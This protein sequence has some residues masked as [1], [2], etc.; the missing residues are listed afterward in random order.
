MVLESYGARVCL[1]S[2]PQEG[3]PWGEGD[4]PWL[5]VSESLRVI[6]PPR[7]FHLG[8]AA[9]SVGQTEKTQ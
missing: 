8:S 9:V 7:S 6:W 3:R 2:S 1:S 4:V 5:E